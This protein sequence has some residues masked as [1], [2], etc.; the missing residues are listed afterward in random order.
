M[1]LKNEYNQMVQ[2][3]MGFRTFY[4]ILHD[5]TLPDDI[6]PY[7]RREFKTG[8]KCWIFLSLKCF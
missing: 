7:D 2:K 4:K 5:E 6:A 3:I 8:S 1:R